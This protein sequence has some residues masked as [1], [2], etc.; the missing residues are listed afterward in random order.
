MKKDF[1]MIFGGIIAYI[2]LLLYAGTLGYMIA[3]VIGLSHAL[4]VAPVSA[5]VSQNLH[6]SEGMTLVVTLIGGLISALVVAKLAETNPG[7]PPQLMRL[8]DTASEKSKKASSALAMIYLIAWLICGLAALITGVMVYP[9]VSQT[10]ADV[11]TTWLGL[12]VA[13]G[14][15]Y[16]GL[17]P[18]R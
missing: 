2:L 12:A 15:A 4:A 6:F 18:Q 17:R 11:G 9:D 1:S 13:S 10:V 14:Y 3:R 5:P 16:F 8:S 7:E